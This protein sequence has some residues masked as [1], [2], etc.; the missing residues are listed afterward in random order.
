MA[1]VSAAP[2]FLDGLNLGGYK[3]SIVAGT[4]SFGAYAAAGGSNVTISDTFGIGLTR[5]RLLLDAPAGADSTWTTTGNYTL[6]G[7]GSPTVSSVKVA[8]DNTWIDL[9]VATMTAGQSYTVAWSGLTG[10]TNGSDGLTAA[11]LANGGISAAS[12]CANNT[13]TG[14]VLPSGATLDFYDSL[15]NVASGNVALAVVIR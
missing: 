15:G 10:I 2:P 9:V 7:T 6:T 12:G 8:P 5:V 3:R 1:A 4:Y 13:F 11:A 14:N